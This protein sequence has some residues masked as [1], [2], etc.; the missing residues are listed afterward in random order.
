[1]NI[2]IAG[3]NGF[4]GQ[5]IKK[6]F[7]TKEN[8]IF[9]YKKK[10][11]KQ[12][13]LLINVAGPNSEYC[14]RYP[15]RS[16]DE[17][18]KINK[19]LLKIAKKYEINN[20]IYISTIHVYKKNKVINISSKLNHKNSYSKSHIESEKYIIK[21]FNKICNFKILRVANCFGYSEKK[22]CKSWAL[23][24]N[25]LVK[26]LVIKK[27]IVILSEENFYRD[28]IS[29]E[30]LIFFIN[31]LI[32]KNNKLKIINVSSNKSRSILSVCED[33]KNLYSKKFKKDIK[34]ISNFKSNGKKY[35]IIS[36][37]FS[38]KLKLIC[39]KFYYKEL[40]DLVNFCRKK[41]VKY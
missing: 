36:N 19:D 24:I 12:I 18:I 28:F 8:R 5:R 20:Y 32:K 26:N 7:K 13:H 1:M 37:F 27:R 35:K 22:H 9:D 29:V 21:N 2:V 14:K 25:N 34:I 39:Q 6:Y 31:N 4:L 38:N 11:P 15:K 3:L 17:R 23:V 33:I 16:I 10:L 41:F 30:Y 40:E